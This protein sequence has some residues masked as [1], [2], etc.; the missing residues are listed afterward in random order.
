MPCF[1]RR[2]KDTLHII[3]NSHFIW[4]S[5]D[6]LYESLDLGNSYFKDLNFTK[7]ESNLSFSYKIISD[8]LIFAFHYATSEKDSDHILSSTLYVSYDKVKTWAN[9][10]NVG[11]NLFIYSFSKQSQK[12]IFGISSK[13]PEIYETDWNLN[14]WR[15]ISTP[16][17][18]HSRPLPRQR[19]P[20]VCIPFTI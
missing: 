9:V 2:V 5:K 17:G 18:I 14:T 13:E 3:S 11:G 1:C 20:A 16:L 6:E 12:I 15:K 19:V 7:P 10:K 8:N 4:I